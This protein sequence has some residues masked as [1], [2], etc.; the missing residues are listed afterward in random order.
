MFSL[1]PFAIVHMTLLAVSP[2]SL[3]R[4]VM[5]T[6]LVGVSSMIICLRKYLIPTK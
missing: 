5:G 1:W 3:P 6:V 2:G 4:Y